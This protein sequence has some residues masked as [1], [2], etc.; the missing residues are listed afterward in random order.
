MANCPIMSQ[1]PT[2]MRVSSPHLSWTSSTMLM[3]TWSGTR[4]HSTTLARAV[5]NLHNASTTDNSTT[6]D[7]VLVCEGHNIPVHR[8]VVAASSPYLAMLV[9]EADITSPLCLVGLRY[10]QAMMV[11]QFMYRGMLEKVSEEEIE[12]LLEATKHL[13]ITG[14]NNGRTVIVKTE[15][16]M[17]TAMEDD[18]V[19]TDVDHQSDNEHA[20][21]LS[22]VNR[23]D[24]IS[25]MFCNTILFFS[26]LQHF[27]LTNTEL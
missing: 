8:L 13:Q 16:E 1:S 4:S 14:L 6:T 10:S 7:L 23:Q 26:T 5:S 18:D 17:E 21:D 12:I 9:R 25:L 27:L 24:L 19:F 15:V 2:L 20:V 3:V 11:V 22:P